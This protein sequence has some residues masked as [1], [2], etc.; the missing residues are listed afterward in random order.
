[1]PQAPS[2]SMRGAHC[3]ARATR[4]AHNDRRARLRSGAME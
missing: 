1:M 3:G 4:Y 2:P